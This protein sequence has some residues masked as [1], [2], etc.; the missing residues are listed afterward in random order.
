MKFK[1]DDWSV[2]QATVLLY[3]AQPLVGR[4]KMKCRKK[5]Y[6]PGHI[7]STDEKM[8]TSSSKRCKG[9]IWLAT[10]KNSWM[11]KP[12][13]MFLIMSLQFT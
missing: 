11:K 7:M 2:S 10:L 8:P 6:I 3:T 4:G 1:A 12:I 5:L 13:G 9:F